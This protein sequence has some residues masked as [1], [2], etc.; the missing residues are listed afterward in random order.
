MFVPAKGY[1]LE[2]IATLLPQVKWKSKMESPRRK[3]AGQQR[4][5]FMYVTDKK[6]LGGLK[7]DETMRTKDLERGNA[8]RKR[9][10][11]EL[12]LEKQIRKDMASG[13]F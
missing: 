6:Y 5:L 3:P 12:S 10:V 1:K 8:K 13:N 4:I 11:A 9:L 7:A 2:R